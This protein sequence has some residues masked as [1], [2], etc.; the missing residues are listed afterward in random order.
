MSHSKGTE[1]QDSEQRE[2]TLTKGKDWKYGDAKE[3]T[4]LEIQKQKPRD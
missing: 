4:E 3:L 1:R 2:G